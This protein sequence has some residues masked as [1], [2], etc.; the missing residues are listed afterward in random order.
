MPRIIEITEKKREKMS[1][2]VE[3]ALYAMGKVMS[4]LEELDGDMGE[5]R[6]RSGRSHDMGSR[7]RYGN[8]HDRSRYDD[9]GDKDDWD[10]DDMDDDTMGER[11]YRSRRMRR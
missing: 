11:R 4:C 2:H 9:Y 8:R 6:S 10:D 5:R 1:G 7:D 3:D